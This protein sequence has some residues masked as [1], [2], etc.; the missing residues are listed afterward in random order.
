M[1]FRKIAMTLAAILA[2]A[3]ITTAGS[4]PVQ[5]LTGDNFTMEDGVLTVTGEQFCIVSTS[6]R[7]FTEDVEKVI[8]KDGVA[9][10]GSMAFQ[11]CSNLR[12]VSLP[13]TLK[14]ISDDAFFDCSSLETIKLPSGITRIE[15]YAFSGCSSLKNIE[16][17]ENVSVIETHA[18]YK[19][20]SL[21]GTLTIP[22]GVTEF[23]YGAFFGCSS[24]KKV[25]LPSTLKTMGGMLM[26][27]FAECT[28]LEEINIPINISEITDGDFEECSSLKRIS[29]INGT[30]KTLGASAFKN[31]ISLES[32]II[33]SSVTRI[34]SNCFEGCTAMKDLA[35]LGSDISVNTFAN[36]VSLENATI[37]C[38]QYSGAEAAAKAWGSTIHHLSDGVVT[39]KATASSYGERKYTCKDCGKSYIEEIP[40]LEIP[41][42]EI[43]SASS[44]SDG[45]KLEWK[46]AGGADGY[47]VYRKISGGDFVLAATTDSV[48]WTDKAVVKDTL[49][50][51]TVAAYNKIQ[52]TEK[53]KPVSVTRL[54]IPIISSLSSTTKGVKIQWSAVSGT[55][56]YLIYRDG[57]QVS[58]VSSTSYVDT[59]A[60]KN[61]TS[62]KYKIVAR[63]GSSGNITTAESEQKQIF[64]LMTQKITSLK[65]NSGRKAVVKYGKNNRATGYQIQYST[66]SKFKKNATKA[67]TAKKATTSV[68]LKNLKKGKKYYVRVRSYKTYGGKTYYS[69]WSAQKSVKISK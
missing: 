47:K 33:P 50:Y 68:T 40:P 66:S 32:L 24:L 60:K 2:I 8:V 31:C 14:Y 48:S 42:P 10:L 58:S 16:I 36:Q 25:I 20:T 55:S 13:D 39:R 67:V 21:G 26:G 44:V 59:G 18:F 27:T 28:S 54:M 69:A 15:S 9:E 64:Y 45:I 53:S 19:C 62:Y 29:L 7:D 17:P 63:K 5:A 34:K 57:K 56:S 4:T 12:Q 51:Y 30:L 22:E 38:M 61:G 35:I 6:L 43:T 49:Y 46:K 11:G 37:H 52:T 1:K 65:N 23:G 3:V 41:V